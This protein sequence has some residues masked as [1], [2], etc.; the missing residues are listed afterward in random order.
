MVKATGT[1]TYRLTADGFH[2]CVLFL[3]LGHR[4]YAPLAAA[5]LNPVAHDARLL[6]EQQATPD[7]LYVGTNHVLDLLLDQ[8]GLRVA[9]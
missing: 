7:R 2:V 5:A 8:L 4:I 9:A 3:K 6:A 1:Q